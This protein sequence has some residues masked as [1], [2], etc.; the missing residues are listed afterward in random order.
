MGGRGDSLGGCHG[1]TYRD[2]DYNNASKYGGFFFVRKS[3]P[4]CSLPDPGAEGGSSLPCRSSS[5]RELIELAAAK[6]PGSPADAPMRITGERGHKNCP[7]FFI[8]NKVPLYRI[9]G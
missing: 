6:N 5:L 3:S 2:L 8:L 4:G 7:S 9:C 1:E